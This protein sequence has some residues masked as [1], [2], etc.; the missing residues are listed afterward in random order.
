MEIDIF[1][2]NGIVSQN[3]LLGQQ[4]ILLKYSTFPYNIRS[5]VT[6]G[7]SNIGVTE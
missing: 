2:K 3:V 6:L 1:L 4:D 5:L 7:R